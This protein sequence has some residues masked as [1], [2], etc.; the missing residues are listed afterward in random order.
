[1]MNYWWVTRPKRRLNDVPEILA[2]ITE[3]FLL[4]EWNGQKNLQLNFEKEL[5]NRNLKKEG[6]R[7]DRRAGGARTYM[8]WIESLGLIFRQQATNKIYLT[9]AGEAIMNGTSP[10]LIL[11]NQIFKYQFPSAYTTTTANARVNKRFKIRPFR[12]MFKLMMDSRINYLTEDEIAKILIVEADSESNRCYN[13][14]VNRII[15]YRKVGDDC[16][17]PDFFDK[18][19]S[20]RAKKAN[21]FNS[22]KDIANTMKCWM[23]YTQLIFIEDGKIYIQ[24]EKRHEVEKIVNDNSKLIDRANDYEYFQRKYGV[25]PSHIKDTRNL[26]RG[27][28]ITKEMIDEIR[29]RKY[30][31]SEALKEPI[32][33]ISVSLIENAVDKL[34][35]NKG[36]IEQVLYKYYPKGGINLFLSN[37]YQ[38][39]FNGR[40]NAIEFEK[41]TAVL[42][43]EIFCFKVKHIGQKGLTPDIEVISEQ[44][45]YTA[46]IDNKA[47]SRYAIT[48][49]HHNRMV[50]NYIGSY[51]DKE[52]PLAFFLYIAGGFGSTIDEQVKK[53]YKETGIHGSA[54]NITNFITLI[55]NYLNFGYSHKTLKNIFMK[56]REIHLSDI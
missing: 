56:N 21:N 29:I 37:Y 27:E 5:E 43:K 26:E 34:G 32:F 46:I 1:M 52:P 51:L 24:Q 23:E 16:L 15:E 54:I 45:N 42:C 53:I 3:N 4:K 48:N 7:R 13:Y 39:A 41:A 35:I 38:M 50:H 19:S 22:Y 55:E 2:M 8:A 36:R 25:D 33:K 11:K 40:E 31:I 47:Y 17:E 30:F 9:L 49:D 44:D 28:R 14:I 18:Y 6:L 12:F 10:V 20:S